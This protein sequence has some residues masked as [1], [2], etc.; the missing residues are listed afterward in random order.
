MLS[1]LIGYYLLFTY[2]PLTLLYNCGILFGWVDNEAKAESD[3][4]PLQYM[5]V[6]TDEG[7]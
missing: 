6:P 2:L 4:S 7:E 3:T 1:H 5:F